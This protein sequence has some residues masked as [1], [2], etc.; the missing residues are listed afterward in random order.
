MHPSLFL[1]ALCLGIASAAPQL[2]QSLDV[3]WSRWKAAHKRLYN[4]NEEG[5]RRA[6]WEKNLKVIEQ[7]NQE[8][9][10]GKHSF[11]TAVNAF[12]DLVSV[13]WVAECFMR[14]VLSALPK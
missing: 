9:S 2:D 7:H 1:A 11:E 6:V 4:K 14:P 12:G 10:Q 13:A 3:R 5:W 8:Y